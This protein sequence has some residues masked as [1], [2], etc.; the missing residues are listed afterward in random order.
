V[1]S[2]F[3]PNHKGI[4]TEFSCRFLTVHSEGL[5]DLSPQD[6][7][8]SGMLAAILLNDIIWHFGLNT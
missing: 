2:L 6:K 3:E 4:F 7:R 1:K 5:R 8:Y